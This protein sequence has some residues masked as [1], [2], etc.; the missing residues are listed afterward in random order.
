MEKEDIKKFVDEEIKGMDNGDDF[1]T[2][3]SLQKLELVMK[4]E[5]EY[6][7]SIEDLEIHDDFDTNMF[8][9]TV[10]NKIINPNK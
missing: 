8:V 10:Y 1:L 5:Q 7:I 3:D 4:C 9:D 2:L 6:F